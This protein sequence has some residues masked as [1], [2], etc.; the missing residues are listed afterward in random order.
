M[1]SHW[2]CKY[3]SKSNLHINSIKLLARQT[4]KDHEKKS[5]GLCYTVSFCSKK[6]LSQRILYNWDSLIFMKCVTVIIGMR[7]YGKNM[8]ILGMKS[9]NIS[10]M[11]RSTVP[12]T[13]SLLIYG[14]SLFCSC[15]HNLLFAPCRSCRLFAFSIDAIHGNAARCFLLHVYC[16]VSSQHF[17]FSV[18]KKVHVNDLKVSVNG[19]KHSWDGVGNRISSNFHYNQAWGHEIHEKEHFQC[20]ERV[21]CSWVWIMTVLVTRSTSQSLGEVVK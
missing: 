2:S 8:Q 5:V 6:S 19:I 17:Y 15:L 3:S 11:T 4:Y 7:I 21:L 20:R 12:R 13:T 1:T 9:V 10:E 16:K 14:V 18:L